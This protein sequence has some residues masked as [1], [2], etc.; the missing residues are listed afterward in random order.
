MPKRFA[1]IAAALARDGRAVPAN[2]AEDW[3]AEALVIGRTSK[4]DANAR[5]TGRINSADRPVNQP[6]DID[7]VYP[8]VLA[9]NE[10]HVDFDA[11][12]DLHQLPDGVARRR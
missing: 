8:R 12:L 1:V 6:L 11:V 9:R 2:I 10:T 3:L 7:H 5:W 4:A